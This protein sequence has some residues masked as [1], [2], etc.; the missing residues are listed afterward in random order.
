MVYLSGSCW[1]NAVPG[2]VLELGLKSDT[3][4]WKQLLEV[5]G[6]CR[7]VAVRPLRVHVPRSCLGSKGLEARCRS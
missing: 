2:P 7:V 6:C 4:A 3:N 1:G 5:Q